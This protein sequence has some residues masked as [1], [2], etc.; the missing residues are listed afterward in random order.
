MFFNR[1]ETESN[2]AYEALKSRVCYVVQAMVFS[3]AVVGL[4][5]FLT[6]GYVGNTGGTKEHE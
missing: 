5:I 2:V 3:V 4:V 1:R 6:V